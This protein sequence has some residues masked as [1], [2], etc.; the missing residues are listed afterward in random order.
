[1]QINDFL[2]VSLILEILYLFH[3]KVISHDPLQKM[4]PNLARTCKNK[5][6]ENKIKPPL[7]C[8]F[9]LNRFP[10]CF[11]LSVLFLV[12]QCVVV[13]VQSDME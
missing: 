11:D 9:F 13:A 1:M 6:Y 7:N 3:K 4:Y 10:L 5:F 2:Y 8:R 12:T